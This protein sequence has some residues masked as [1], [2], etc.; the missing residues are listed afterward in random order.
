MPTDYIP[1]FQPSPYTRTEMYITPI[2]FRTGWTAGVQF[3]AG[4]RD[5]SLLHSVQTDSR[6]HPASY[7]RRTE[8]SFPGGKAAGA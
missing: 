1:T 7:T 2:E 6:A 3:P 8:G 4:T 5:F